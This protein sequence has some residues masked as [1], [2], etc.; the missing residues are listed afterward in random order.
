MDVD[1]AQFDIAVG[2][3]DRVEQLPAAEHPAR[4][5]HEKLQQ[6]EFGRAEADGLLAVGPERIAPTLKGRRFLNQL[7]ERF[8]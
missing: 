1:R 5:L 4:V 6:P 7:L 8:L 2:P 3:P